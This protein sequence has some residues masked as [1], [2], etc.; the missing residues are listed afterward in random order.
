[1]LTLLLCFFYGTGAGHERMKKA[2][3]IKGNPLLFIIDLPN[4]KKYIATLS[5]P[6]K[7]E[8]FVQFLEGYKQNTLTALNM[9]D[10]V[11]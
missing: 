4:G 3:K 2:I 9:T 6:A 7:E 11:L 5:G 1:M 8:D 10:D